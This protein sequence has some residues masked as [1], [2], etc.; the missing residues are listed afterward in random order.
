[1]CGGAWLGPGQDRAYAPPA[2]LGGA[3][4]PTWAR[5]GNVGGANGGG[6]GYPGAVAGGGGA[7]AAPHIGGAGGPPRPARR[8]GGARGSAV[9]GRAVGEW[10]GRNGLPGIGR[11]LVTEPFTEIFTSDPAEVS[12]LHAFFL[13]HSHQNLR[14]LT[15]IEGGA[16]QD[17]VVGGMGALQSRICKR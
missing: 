11:E 10:R 1:D 8:R 15:S 12:L 5:G 6:G 7:G 13:I 4:H 2:G 16:Q 17:R 3:T 14:H 9:G